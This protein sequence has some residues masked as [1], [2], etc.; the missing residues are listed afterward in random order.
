MMSGVVIRMAQGLGLHRDGTHFEGFTTYEVELRRRVWWALCMLDVRASEDQGTDL[1][2]ATG[3]FDTNLPLN[4][5]DAD[6]H[7]E[8]KVMPVNRDGVTDMSLCIVTYETCDL[9]RQMM[10]LAAKEGGLRLDEQE[11]LI[12]EMYQR[13]ERGYFQHTTDSG[14]LLYW[15]ASNVARL[16]MAKMRLIVY[17][18]ILFSSEGAHFSD[19]LQDTLF[20]SAI[21][22]A[23]YS[24]ALNAETA[25][26]HWRWGFQ[27][28]THWY[29]IVHLLLEISRRP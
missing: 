4:I 25:C 12:N 24:H 26:R 9:T 5:N 28:Y 27:T 6:I 3:N 18:P 23:E 15:V 17:L 7:P 8:S 21:E 20:V 22:V 13:Y 14:S 10:A 19:E 11:R 1:A 29:A 2:I 16:V